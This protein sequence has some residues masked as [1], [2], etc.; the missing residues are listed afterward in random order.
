VIPQPVPAAQPNG[1]D[2]SGCTPGSVR[3]SPAP[4]MRPGTWPLTCG[5]WARR[6]ALVLA[7]LTASADNLRTA[8]RAL[9][10]GGAR[11]EGMPSQLPGLSSSGAGQGRPGS[12]PAGALGLGLD[13]CPAA[14]RTIGRWEDLPG[15][16]PPYA[17]GV[18]ERPALSPQATPTT[19]P[20]PLRSRRS[21]LRLMALL[22]AV[23]AVIVAVLWVVFGRETAL[24]C[25][26]GFTAGLIVQVIA[27]VIE[28]RRAR[29]Q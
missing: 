15:G 19:E 27:R 11:S 12:Q 1:A 2:E 7:W 14:V 13:A 22:V 29:D 18:T 8:T 4:K 23:A 21:W 26:G 20:R 6:L 5:S 16:E 9:R 17:A 3:A 24:N 28:V 25:G 10:P